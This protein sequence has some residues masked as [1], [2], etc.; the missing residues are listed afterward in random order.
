[1]F[2]QYMRGSDSRWGARATRAK[3]TNQL[4]SAVPL[5]VVDSNVA[6]YQDT[7]FQELRDS[8]PP[9][10]GM[11]PTHAYQ[12]SFSPP[13]SSASPQASHPASDCE[14]PLPRYN[15]SAHLIDPFQGIEYISDTSCVHD[16]DSESNL[17]APERSSFPE[18]AALR[19]ATDHTIQPEGWTGAHLTSSLPYACPP[20]TVSEHRIPSS[21]SYPTT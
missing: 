2:E 12:V 14:I 13:R 6:F 7:V 19:M 17:V 21:C 20:D 4:Y 3:G 11:F 18:L 16:L 15:H 5:R 1:M 9:S 10:P 8:S